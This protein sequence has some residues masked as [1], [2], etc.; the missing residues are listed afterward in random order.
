MT[1]DGSGQVPGDCLF[2]GRYVRTCAGS[3]VK[4]K[5]FI[6]PDDPEALT[7]WG[8][9]IKVRIGHLQLSYAKGK[10]FLRQFCGLIGF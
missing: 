8:L 5:I 3:F 10:D 7:T 4:G 9:K 6:H 1:E 2:D